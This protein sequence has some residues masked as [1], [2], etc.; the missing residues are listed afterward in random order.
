MVC[1]PIWLKT[2]ILTICFCQNIHGSLLDG[3]GYRGYRDIIL[4]LK[5]CSVWN[6]WTRAALWLPL[7]Q[8]THSNLQVHVNR[9]SCVVFSYIPIHTYFLAK[10]MLLTS[11]SWLKL[12]SWVFWTQMTPHQQDGVLCFCFFFPC[13]SPSCWNSSVLWNSRTEKSERV[14]KEQFIRFGWTS[15]LIKIKHVLTFDDFSDFLTDVFSCRP[16]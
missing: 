5:C 7:R 8:P 11:R 2:V 16:F 6:N 1:C 4:F 13:S 3:G 14:V 10:K 9:G 12:D 15:P